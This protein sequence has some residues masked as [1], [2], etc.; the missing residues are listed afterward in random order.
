MRFWSAIALLLLLTP[1]V[2]LSDPPT[3]I[4]YEQLDPQYEFIELTTSLFGPK[5]LYYIDPNMIF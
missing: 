4:Y 1:S 2:A 5:Q 3:D